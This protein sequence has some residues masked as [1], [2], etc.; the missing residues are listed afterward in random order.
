[1]MQ[2]R[3]GRYRMNIMQDAQCLGTYGRKLSTPSL[4]DEFRAWTNRLACVYAV[5]RMVGPGWPKGGSSA[6]TLNAMHAL[7]CTK[8]CYIMA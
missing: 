5:K 6:K 7:N 2:G 8:G 3:N 1:M 4:D